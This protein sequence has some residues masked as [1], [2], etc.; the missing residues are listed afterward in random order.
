MNTRDDHRL[1]SGNARSEATRASILDAAERLFAERGIA[2][3]SI[4]DIT[5][6]AEANLGAINYHF[7]SKQELVAHVFR[8]RL[9]PLME[10]RAALLE[11][12]REAAGDRPPTVEALL[13][14]LIRPVAEESFAHGRRNTVFVRLMARLESEPDPEVERLL[15]LYSD[16]IIG[17]FSASLRLALPHL[18]PEELFWRMR[19]TMGALHDALLTASGAPE[20][21]HLRAKLDADGLVRRLA[22]FAAAG[23]R[24]PHARSKE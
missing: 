9:E 18:P 2:G 16:T 11:A 6:A 13:D 22:A 7:G 19:F 17:G 8:R 23:L 20:G 24:A 5:A 12:A 14:A 4:R 21:K 10:R 15:R 1:T 3:T